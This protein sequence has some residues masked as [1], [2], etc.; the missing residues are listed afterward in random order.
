M[1]RPREFDADDALD[2]ALEVF[3]RKGYEGAS[4]TELTAAMGIT[5]PSLY[6]AFGNK[7]AL[8]RKALCRYGEIHFAFVVE[9][10]GRPEARDVVEHMLTGFAEAQTS[11]RCPKGCLTVQGALACGTEAESIRKELAALRLQGERALCRRLE[12]AKTEGQLP[13]GAE[14]ADLARYVMA[15]ANGMAVQ[16]AGGATRRDLNRVVEMAM[17]AWPEARRPSRQMATV[18]A[19]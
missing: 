19:S 15:V 17:R 12:R 14:P 6:A 10:M 3:W 4:L 2:R 11:P 8:F 16:A 5:R 13:A 9:A 1:G 18:A 7:E